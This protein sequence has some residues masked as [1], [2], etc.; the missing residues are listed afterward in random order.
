MK[1][2]R[3]VLCC[4]LSLAMLLSVLPAGLTVAN[5]KVVMETKDGYLDFEAEDTSY[6]KDKLSLVK[7]SKLYSN[8]KALSVP[9]EDKDEP[10]A[11][12]KAHIDLSFKADVGGTYT[13][14]MRATA[15][16]TSQ[17]G[18]SIYFSYG[19]KDQPY[20]WTKINGEPE[21]P[22]WTKLCS[23]NVA[24]GET[25]YARLR[26]RQ[27]MGIGFDRFIITND[28]SFRP[29]D[30]A[31]GIA[32]ATPTPSPVSTPNASKVA[33]KTE[34]G[35]AIV[36]AE[37]LSYNKDRFEVV[38]NKDASGKK[39]L[40]VTKEDKT[41]PPVTQ[42]ADIDLSFVT[43]KPGT[44]YVWMRNTA[45]QENTSGNSIF[46]SVGSDPYKYFVIQG[47]PTEFGW[48]KLGAV[49]V[50]EAG[51]VGLMRLI[52]RQSYNVSIDK[53]IVTSNKAFN[54]T[55]I[56]PDPTQASVSTLPS[57]VYPTPSITPPAS[58]P[59]VFF[60]AA[61]IPTL[62]ANLDAEQ[63]AAA[64]AAWEK[65]MEY[66]SDGTLPAPE[67]GKSN[68]D[69]KVFN[70]I[71]AKAYDYA[72]NKNAEHGK[73]A[74]E[75]MKKALDTADFVNDQFAVRAYGRMIMTVG[76]VYDWCYDLISDDDRKLLIANTAA[77]ASNLSIGYPPNK[78][79]VIVGHGA[80]GQLLQ[81]L[82]SF[83]IAT[84]NEQ[85][86]IYNYVAGRFFA[87]YVEP[88]NYYYQSGS[89]HQGSA[90]ARYGNDILCAWMFKR[91]S[92][93][94]V[95]SDDFHDVFYE[96]LYRRRPDGQNIR[97]GDDFNEYGNQR[98]TFWPSYLSTLLY[99]SSYYN[100]PYLKREYQKCSPNMASF[101][102]DTEGA[103]TP[104]MHLILN[105]PNL[106]GKSNAAL[107]LTSY[108]G[109]PNGAMIARTGWND[110]YGSTD[111]I[112]Y[113]K[114]GERWAANHEHLD[115]GNFQLYYKGILA[116]ES[117]YY[118]S[119]YGSK[120]DYNY[121]KRGI[122][123]NI[124]TVYD[125]DEEMNYYGPVANDGGQKTPMNGT[126]PVTMKEWMDDGYVRASVTAHEYGPDPVKPEYSYLAGDI[127]KAYSEKV[128]EV[129]RSMVFL[130]LE[131][132]D[133]PATFIVMDK[134]T[135]ANENFQKNWLL[136]MQEEPQIDGNKIIVTRTDGEYNGRM[137]NE[138]LLPKSVDITKIGGEGK[139][140]MIG[141]TNYDYTVTPNAAAEV[142]WGRV[143]V[144]PTEANKTDYFLNVMTVS[145]ADTT[146]ADLNSTLIEG[147]NYAGAVI[148]DRVAVFAKN[149]DRIQNSLSF[150]IPGS[151]EYKVFVAGLTAGTWTTSTGADVIVTEDG[152]VAY[153]T[154]P[155]GAVTLTY[156]DTN[157]TR[158]EINF[159]LEDI[160]TIGIKVGGMYIHSDVPA[161]IEN[162]RTLVPMRAI[163]EALGADVQWDE[164][165]ATATASKDGREVKITE[166]SDK[167]YIDGA[168]QLLDVTAMTRNDR[169]VVPVRF[170]SESFNAKVVWDPF[171]QTV[172]I[173]PGIIIKPNENSDVA[174]IIG[175]ETSG[176]FN[177][178]VG[179]YSFDGDLDT[180]WSVEGD[181]QWIVYEF[182]KEYTVESAY[183]YLNKA[184]ERVAYFDLL[185][186]T[187]GVTYTPVIT[188][189]KGDGK[190]NGETFTFPTPVKAKYIKYMAKG[191]N[192]SKW[193]AI[194]EIQFNVQK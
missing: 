8:G 150:E 189:G 58:H 76:K 72:I 31:L 28:T 93:T 81:H 165:T 112:A 52:A 122:A 124:L 97:T 131:D 145:D 148:S 50:S 95:L 164:S 86:D 10:P 179:E 140:F 118:G 186:S 41:E 194:K 169:F 27:M 158:E 25:G 5:A 57:G 98:S 108:Y 132:S 92:G 30:V 146:A 6:D 49:T 175:C 176:D 128:G 129:L 142:G 159:T 70:A 69:Y 34:K 121:H 182:D 40:A 185:A 80:E 174:S 166:G 137:V 172:L 157:A 51:G 110:G 68:F 135:S 7:D 144:S 85:P 39:A 136:H 94:D 59:R 36:E 87:E 79:G 181:D 21:E 23:L 127:T 38:E 19:G 133:H 88:R 156:K 22:A 54:P 107:P 162:D 171:S 73:S 75:M 2:M 3:K 130:P 17:A 77:H 183:I 177:N 167:A 64:K 116:S 9:A 16:V 163:F 44:Y 82:M 187:D 154:A 99:G 106:Q 4:I 60:T 138:T 55:G 151:G 168:E 29:D 193:N 152:G 33:I 111:A 153:F 48:T 63:N 62:K 173:T 53:F 18:Q 147:D 178:E 45:T 117:G 191:N 12:A 120:H 105:D 180:L 37:S 114:I 160:E 91:M 190:T 170:V 125:P 42:A 103:Y 126:E 102:E 100:D 188:D 149:K 96:L 13:I 143:E 1:K 61:D 115:A 65:S 123:H 14:W 20:T 119:G 66:A 47:T 83:A 15:S 155:A 161:F 109:S 26:V 89:Y 56:D 71:E 24:A 134:V 74:V 78:M 11:D 184:T 101:P 90:Y 104:T 192:T 141:D 35:S 43:D 113:M 67:A 32:K 139:Q 84:Y 46:L